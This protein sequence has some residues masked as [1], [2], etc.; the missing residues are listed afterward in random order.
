MVVP[1]SCPFQSTHPF[2]EQLIQARVSAAGMA[3]STRYVSY[4]P[5][6]VSARATAPVSVRSLT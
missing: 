4:P 5:F 2:I 1:H 6:S 3:C